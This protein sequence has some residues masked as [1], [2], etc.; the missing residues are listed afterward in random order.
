MRGPSGNI[1]TDAPPDITF[2][3]SAQE[4]VVT[5][6]MKYGS[7]SCNEIAVNDLTLTD[8]GALMVTVGAATKEDT[9]RTCTDDNVVAEYELVISVQGDLPQH[10]QVTE[11]PYDGDPRQTTATPTE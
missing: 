6:G 1:E 3:Q 8:A 4:V 11:R 5:G 9:P 2:R 7:G 10:V